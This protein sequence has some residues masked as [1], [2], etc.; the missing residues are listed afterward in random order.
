[1]LDAGLD[2]LARG[3]DQALAIRL[4][5][6]AAIL[7]VRT[8]DA[9]VRHP[10]VRTVREPELLVIDL[11]AERALVDVERDRLVEP[12]P[13]GIDLRATFLRPVV[14]EADTRR[15]VAAQVHGV[16]AEL[17]VRERVDG[18]LQETRVAQRL[19]LVANTGV[20]G[21]VRQDLPRVAQVRG[22]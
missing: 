17:D 13:V 19:I 6:G 1:G 12:A 10:A 22:P 20:E 3:A 8:A 15:P 18:V 4:A 16:V 2:Q 5:G 14:E 11:A 7:A 21:Q 9:R